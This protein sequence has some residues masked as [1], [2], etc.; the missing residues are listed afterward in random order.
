M[1]NHNDILQEIEEAAY[2]LIE[3]GAEY[4]KIIILAPKY[5]ID[6]LSDEFEKITGY[7][8]NRGDKMTLLGYNV[9]PSFENEITVYDECIV[10]D[11]KRCPIKIKLY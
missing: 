9:F 3:Y 8:I 10:E 4:N 6:K 5:Y 11:L 2:H 7:K 1:K